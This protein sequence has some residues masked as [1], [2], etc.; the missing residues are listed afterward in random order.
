MKVLGSVHPLDWFFYC[1]VDF[2]RSVSVLLWC[3]CF[4]LNFVRSCKAQRPFY[5]FIQQRTLLGIKLID[6]FHITNSRV[7]R[8]TVNSS[9]LFFLT[10][11]LIKLVF[12]VEVLLF[13]T[14]G[15]S[16]TCYWIGLFC[17][18]QPFK[19]TGNN[20]GNSLKIT[21]LHRE[22]L[23][24]KTRWGNIT[25]LFP[26]PFDD[27]KT[28]KKDSEAI[29]KAMQLAGYFKNRRYCLLWVLNAGFCRC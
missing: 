25:K 13:K 4:F 23:S 24:C 10:A 26:L 8:F 12:C 28:L 7:V 14:Q 2:H 17:L 21:T 18:K 16:I 6:C 1:L 5:N 9:C 15:L 3:F 19:V 22:N 29:L 11:L 27:E 20:Q